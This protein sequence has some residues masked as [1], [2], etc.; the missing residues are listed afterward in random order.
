MAPPISALM[1]FERVQL[2]R[3]SY[4]LLLFANLNIKN[5]VYATPFSIELVEVDENAIVFS[6][7]LSEGRLQN[8]LPLQFVL[9][10]D[11][12]SDYSALLL[13]L[14]NMLLFRL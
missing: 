11:L 6:S 1:L 10:T 9:L 12:K 3:K 7:E 8:H 13:P 14:S 2:L 5:V 4:A